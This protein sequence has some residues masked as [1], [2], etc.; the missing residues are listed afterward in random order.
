MSNSDN[1]RQQ[2]PEEIQKLVAEQL[3]G[4]QCIDTTDDVIRK[5]MANLS[6]SPFIVEIEET[7]PP[8]NAITLYANNDAL[9]CKIFA[10]TELSLVFTKEYSSYCSIKKKSD[11][12]FNMK[13]DLKESFCIYVKRFKVEKAKIVECDDSITCSAFRK[14]LPAD[15]PLFEELI[16]GKNLSLANSYALAEKHSFWD[17]EKC[18]QKPPEQSHRDA[19]PTQK[20]ANDKPLDNKIEP[21]DKPKDRSLTKGVTSPKTYTKFSIP[22]NQIF[23]NLKDK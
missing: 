23:H 14:G 18:S 11:Y 3:R 12:L 16:M 13:N 7:K 9:M 22:I 21:G 20:K 6:R 10:T 8:R 4:F 19:E 1:E 2:I 5:D 15:H 17:E